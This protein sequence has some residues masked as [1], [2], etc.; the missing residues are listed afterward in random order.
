M[1]NIKH[2]AWVKPVTGEISK[3][4]FAKG[5]N[6]PAE[7][8]DSDQSLHIVHITDVIERGDVFLRTK[9]RDLDNNTWETRGEAPNTVSTWNGTQWTYTQE[10]VLTIIRHERNSRL[11]QTDWTQFIDNGLDSDTKALWVTYRQAL[12]DVPTQVDGTT[13]TVDDVTWPTAP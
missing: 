7:G 1:S 3:L 8:Y 4:M 10:G 6:N 2:I 5:A 9:Y 11:A 13:V 12:R